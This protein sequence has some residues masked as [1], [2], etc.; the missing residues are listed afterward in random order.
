[1][2]RVRTPPPTPLPINSGQIE[3]KLEMTTRKG[4]NFAD[5]WALRATHFLCIPYLYPI[6]SND[7]VRVASS[8]QQG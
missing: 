3:T 4:C 1:M 6:H 5:G 2:G 8:L 7:N